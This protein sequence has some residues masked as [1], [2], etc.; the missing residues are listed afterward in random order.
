VG[1]LGNSGF[2]TSQLLRGLAAAAAGQLR[3]DGSTIAAGLTRGAELARA[4]VV[5][6][7]EGTV[8]TVARA[9][10]H[11]AV[12][13]ANAPKGAQ[14]LARVVVAAVDAAD[15]AL[16]RTPSQLRALADAGVVDAG[17][18]GL[19]LMLAALA[20]TVTGA[21]APLAPVQ[22]PA[23][24]PQHTANERRYEVQYRLDASAAAVD[25]LCDMLSD[26][27]DSIAVVPTGPDAWNVHVHVDAVGPAI[28]AGIEAGRPHQIS[29]VAL[30]HRSPSPDRVAHRRAV[31][32]IAPGAG[33]AHLFEHEGAQ[34]VP[35]GPQDLPT[36]AEVVTA[37]T[38]S[39]ARDVVLLP[40]AARVSGV[41]EAAAAQLRGTG[42]RVSV[43]PTRSPVQALAAVAVHDADRRFE[44]DAV[45]MAEAAA[46]T[47][48]A[49]VTVAESAGLT[50]VGICQPGDILGLI[51]GEVVEIGRGLLAVAFNLVDRLLRVGAELM[52]IVVG[53]AAP[54]GAG[55]V[56]RT[57]V[58]SQAPLTDVAVYNGGQG[59][60]AVIIGVE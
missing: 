12:A 29:V 33:L 13:A 2:I 15:A 21:P 19:V 36:V 37:I 59:D 39:G 4:A 26:V 16:Q 17:G 34:V 56:L 50:A 42:V 40:N 48:H 55:E 10:A 6:P 45:A 46:A 1:A 43:V 44:D 11:A 7:V 9:A 41:A 18:R 32:A 23:R 49:E 28:E 47:R 60:H 38:G 24:S 8:L 5:E 22:V 31:F 52:T 3:C 35:D 27:G 14:T 57:H 30:E 51:D 58:R 25:R 53:A 20:Q 54:P